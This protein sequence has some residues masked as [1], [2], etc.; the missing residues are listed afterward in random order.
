[1]LTWSRAR[2]LFPRQ[3]ERV[4]NVAMLSGGQENVAYFERG[5]H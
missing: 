3:T 2:H 1:M 4:Y 5:N